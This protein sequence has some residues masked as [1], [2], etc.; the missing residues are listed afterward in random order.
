[1]AIRSME[2][3]YDEDVMWRLAMQHPSD[4]SQSE[5]LDWL[6]PDSEEEDCASG[7]LLK[8]SS[9]G[10]RED[11]SQENAKGS[12]PILSKNNLACLR[13]RM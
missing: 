6:A 9:T 8:S 7:A 1:M 5:A 2:D 11:E 4:R 10:V 13:R 3:A 12:E